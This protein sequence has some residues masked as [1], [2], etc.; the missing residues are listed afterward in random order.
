MSF[1]KYEAY[2]DSGVEWLGEVPKNWIVKKLG[3]VGEAI[4]GLTYSPDDV[5]DEGLLVLRS[6]NVQNG[7]ISLHDNVFVDKAV[8]QKLIVK[9]GDIL[10]CSR[11]GSRD[12]IGKN[13]LIDKDSEGM[14]FGAFMTIYRSQINQFLFWVFNSY[15][16]SA[17][18]GSFMTSTVNQLT[19]GTLNSFLVP[20]PSLREQTQI[21]RFLDHE[22][23]RIDALIAEQ[24]RL[25][26]L[27]KEK[28]QAVIS[29]AVTKGLDPTAPMKDSGVEW[30]GEVPA[31]W[32]MSRIGW[33]CLVGNGCTPSRDKLDYWENGD[34]PWLNSSKVNLERVLEADQFVTQKA[35]KECPLPIVNPGTV[36]IAIT[37]EGKTR[38]MTTIT[39]IEATIN[40]HLA[41]I[42][43]RGKNLSH[44]FLHD[45]LSANYARIRHESEG[46]G[47]TKAAITCSDI[48]SFPLPLPP[49]DEQESIRRFI[50]EK[51]SLLNNL[52]SQS[53]E[54]MRLLQERRSA[55]IS[56]AVTGK[57]DVRGWQPPASAAPAPTLEPAH[58]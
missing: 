41:F 16:F 52:I 2:K 14:T 42:E 13:A 26:E 58:G 25:I 8:P 48:R 31:H 39:E 46:W 17:Q 4:I 43:H 7:M 18:S 57:I 47:S 44:E 1:P 6:S 55:L 40:Q 49:I 56:A 33:Q 36:L 11:N 20:V 15:I 50:Q 21:A 35:L 19:T 27:L 53:K 5:V 38:G 37:G 28:R 45:W 32:E 22:T 34:Y 9:E 23:A 29:H 3:F 54:N 24:Q 30:L 51:L 10:I 12:L